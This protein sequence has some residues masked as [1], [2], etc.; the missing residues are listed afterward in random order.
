VGTLE[1]YYDDLD[2]APSKIGLK[3]GYQ[4]WENGASPG[5]YF[6]AIMPNG[7]GICHV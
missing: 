1:V 5:D 2:L 6:N 4:D 3:A 7:V